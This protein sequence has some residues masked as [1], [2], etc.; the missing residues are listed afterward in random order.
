LVL[1][2]AAYEAAKKME[3]ELAESTEASK[4]ETKTEMQK[5]KDSIAN[6]CQKV[7][8]LFKKQENQS[9]SKEEDQDGNE[10]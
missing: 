9:E 10:N 3:A 5:L 7:K 1:E 6:I 2:N 8:T 4:T